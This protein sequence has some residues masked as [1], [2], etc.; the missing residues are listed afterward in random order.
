MPVF[1]CLAGRSVLPHPCLGSY[2]RSCVSFFRELVDNEVV[3][4]PDKVEIAPEALLVQ[5]DAL[6]EQQVGAWMPVCDAFL[7]LAQGVTFCMKSLKTVIEWGRGHVVAVAHH[8]VI[9]LMAMAGHC[10][11]PLVRL[12]SACGL[13]HQYPLVGRR[14]HTQSHGE[15][16]AAHVS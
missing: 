7:C 10:G 5:E 8:Q 15:L 1:P 2:F 3:L 13:R 11:K 16:L 6:A 14:F 9:A 4:T 12:W